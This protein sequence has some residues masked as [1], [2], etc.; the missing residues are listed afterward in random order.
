VFSGTDVTIIEF[1]EWILEGK[2]LSEFLETH[3]DLTK[4]KV[5]AYL[6]SGLADKCIPNCEEKW[7]A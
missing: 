4:E 1:A 5:F 3:P 7:W 2:R 6:R